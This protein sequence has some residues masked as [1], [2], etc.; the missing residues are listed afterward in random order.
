MF[1]IS[2]PSFCRF[3]RLC[4]YLIM[5]TLHLL[6]V[7]ATEKILLRLS[8]QLLPL[9]APVPDP[10]PGIVFPGEE[11]EN[12]EEIPQGKLTLS[13]ISAGRA[14]K[15]DLSRVREAICFVCSQRTSAL[16]IVIVMVLRMHRDSFQ[17]L[18]FLEIF[19]SLPIMFC[20]TQ[21]ELTSC[22]RNASYY[23]PLSF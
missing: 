10:A 15:A 21:E 1:T 7:K 8:D 16:S 13:M 5:T 3:I 4:D 6:V 17:R 18:V 14:S 20:L 22:S 23:W 19:C 11:E 2:I 12:T 9:G